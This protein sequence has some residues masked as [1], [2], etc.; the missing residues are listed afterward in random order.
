MSFN[1]FKEY[2]VSS[3]V[4][5]ILA[6]MLPNQSKYQ[7]LWATTSIPSFAGSRESI[8]YSTTTNST[9]T[10]I[11]GKKT[12]N[13]VEVEIAWNRDTINLANEIADQ[14]LQYAVIDLNDFTGWEFVANASYRMA[15]VAP[16]SAKQMVLQLTIKSVESYA[17]VDFYDTYMDTITFGELPQVVHLSLS[18]DATNGKI[19][20]VVTEP[21]SAKATAKSNADSVATASLVSG[22]LTIKPVAVDDTTI[23]VS[24]SANNYASAKREI[25]VIVEE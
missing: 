23:V 9:I 13:E 3:G 19:Y 20:K 7:I 5:T 1:E 11:P 15:D 10:K 24:A 12:T 22:T 8:D 16:D 17:T 21:S 6:V 2:W 18:K 14:D 4:G 25:L